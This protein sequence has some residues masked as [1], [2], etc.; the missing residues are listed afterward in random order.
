[1]P[2]GLNQKTSKRKASRKRLLDFRV[3]TQG[4]TTENPFRNKPILTFNQKIAK[5]LEMNVAKSKISPFLPLHPIQPE[6]RKRL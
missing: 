5:R 6:G 2:P 4:K 1:L 3:S